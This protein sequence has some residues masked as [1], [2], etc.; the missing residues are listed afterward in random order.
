MFKEASTVLPVA[1]PLKKMK[2]SRNP[3]SLQ[4]HGLQKSK[5]A[6]CCSRLYFQSTDTAEFP[7]S[8]D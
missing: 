8:V 7:C 2:E 3:D 1:L 6:T 4:V 5:A